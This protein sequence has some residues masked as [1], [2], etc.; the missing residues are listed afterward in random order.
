MPIRIHIQL[1]ISIG[2][3]LDMDP[4]FFHNA[5]P[6]PG[7]KPMRIQADPDPYPVQTLKPQK[8]TFYI[9]NILNVAKR[10]KT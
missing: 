3:D 5:D 9:K 7:K 1:F 10:L 6:D 8:V 2:T 4:A